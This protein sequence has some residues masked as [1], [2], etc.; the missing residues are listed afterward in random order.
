MIQN[1]NIIVFSDD[2]GRNPS[3]LQHIGKILAKSNR[4]IWVG[5]LGLRQPKF[6]LSDFK[7]IIEKFR[8]IF[9]RGKRN[10]SNNRFIEF[11][12]VIIPLNDIAIIRKINSYI[13]LWQIKR[14]INTHKFYRP[15]LI[16]TSPIIVDLM[17]KLDES[18]SHY[19]CL[20]DFTL[21]DGA[22]NC[23]AKLE[24]ELLEKVNTS[25]SVSEV[26]MHSRIPSSGKNY[27]LP[28]GVDI[29]H[30]NNQSEEI[31]NSIK[32]IVKPVIGFFGLIAPWIDVQLID[33]CAERYSNF[34]FLIIGKSTIELNEMN[35]RPNIKYLGEV[36]YQQL[37]LYAKVFNV[38]LIPFK[39]NNLTKAANPLKLLEYLTLGIPVV[40]TDLPEIQKF[41]RFVY[42]AQNEQE[43]IDLIQKAVNDSGEEQKLI[44]KMEAQKYSWNLITENISKCILETENK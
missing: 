19:F 7:R 29:E 6:S 15:I 2:W 17:G 25:F 28:Q 14:S 31:P 22:F 9:L 24:K 38:G 21:F 4:I 33:R 40:A 20:D 11:N 35:K 32:N 30:F 27:F 8:Q 26:L 34:T 37:P 44:R 5:S 43:F 42:I 36:P 10:D 39:I 18:S 23:I 41:S 1:R 3:T 16:T 12:P 13:L